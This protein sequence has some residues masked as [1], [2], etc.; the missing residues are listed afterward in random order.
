MT[1]DVVAADKKK[2]KT[3]PSLCFIVA[4]AGFFAIKEQNF[5]SEGEK[6]LPVFTG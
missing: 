5:T 1:A 6:A 4:L 2:Q 3:Q